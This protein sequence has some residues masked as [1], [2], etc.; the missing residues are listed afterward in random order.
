MYRN[1]MT[2]FAAACVLAAGCATVTAPARATAAGT[3]AAADL[4]QIGEM[5]VGSWK[6]TEPVGVPGIESVVTMHVAPIFV[7]GIDNTYYV[8]LAREDD[9]AHPYRQAVFSLYEFEGSP[10]LRTYE[11]RNNPGLQPTL[12]GL[13]AVPEIFPSLNAESFVATL[14]VD[15]APDGDGWA[16]ST[17]YPY[18]TGVGG[19]VQMTSSVSVTPDS[20]TLEDRGYAADGS[21]AWGPD[22]GAAYHF[23]RYEP[24]IDVK[25]YDQ[26]LVTIDLIHP[27]G[28][29]AVDGDRVTVHYT[30]WVRDQDAEIANGWKF[31]SSYD[32]PNGPQP[33]TFALP[34]R[35]I[36]GWN[37]GM[38]NVTI[39]TVR[40]LYIP[41]SLGYGAQTAAG[42][43]IPANSDLFFEVEVLDVIKPDVPADGGAD[44][45]SG[46]EPADE[47]AD[48][49]DG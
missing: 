9:T 34:G 4:G 3:T 14:D 7:S 18:P 19:A 32:R 28:E 17:P 39:G 35:L 37:L 16:G 44:D 8:E 20:I 45:Q 24:G 21:L 49:G 48:N 26:G 1:T 43:R 42:G 25:L 36:E 15:L 22:E 31:D 23:V 40:R 10:R 41:S 30:G 6:T 33:F 2:G 12:V 47:P 11:F 29:P 38:Q 46:D 27:E 13:W 5:L